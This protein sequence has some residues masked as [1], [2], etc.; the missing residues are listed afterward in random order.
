MRRQLHR[1]G[2]GSGSLAA[3]ALQRQVRQLSTMRRRPRSGSDAM[4]TP[5][6][7]ALW[8]RCRSEAKQRQLRRKGLRGKGIAAIRRQLRRVGPG[9][10]GLAEE[11]LQRQLRRRG[12]AAATSQRR[13]CGSNSAEKGPCEGASQRQRCGGNSAEKG[14]REGGIA[15]TSMRWQ[16]RRKGPG[17]GGLAATAM[18]RNS[19]VSGTQS[20]PDP[21]IYARNNCKIV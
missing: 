4:A 2:P 20:T 1:K 15:S 17:G 19:A 12:S 16:L 6:K 3:K 9:G 8:R 7:P 13:R 10:G 14:P 11:M 21:L 5:R 18:Q